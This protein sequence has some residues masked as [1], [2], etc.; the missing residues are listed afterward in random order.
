MW[1]IDGNEWAQE[2]GRH[3]R[4][5]VEEYTAADRNR[6]ERLNHL[7]LKVITPLEHF[8]KRVKRGSGEA[9]S[10]A[11]YRL[12]EDFEAAVNLRL[13]AAALRENGQAGLADEQVR[14][15][16]IL[17]ESLNQCAIVLGEAELEESVFRAA[18]PGYFRAGIAS[19]P[20]GLDRVTVGSADRIRTDSRESYFI[21]R[22]PKSS[23][24]VFI[25]Y[26]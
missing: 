15:W 21:R 18:A 1:A 24:R 22:R 3:P 20:Q 8:S 5:F 17:M 25:V 7:R 23:P 9:L 10:A 6:L 26:F 16:D 2:W 11:V 13:F 4:G 12:L 19:I 14:L